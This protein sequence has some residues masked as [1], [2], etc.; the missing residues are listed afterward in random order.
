VYLPSSG[1]SGKIPQELRREPFHFVTVHRHPPLFSRRPHESTFHS[2]EIT[3]CIEA[4]SMQA[5]PVVGLVYEVS[6]ILFS[7]PL[8]P[9]ERGS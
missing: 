8:L 5:T 1:Y 7:V 6:G 9:T 2:D 4:P 3:L